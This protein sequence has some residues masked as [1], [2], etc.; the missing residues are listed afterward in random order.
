M[1]QLN[2]RIMRLELKNIEMTK[3]IEILEQISVD[4]IPILMKC[5]CVYNSVKSKTKLNILKQKYNELKLNNNNTNNDNNC[6]KIE[7]QI[8]N[9]SK[10][11]SKQLKENAKEF[12][13]IC[14]DEDIKESTEEPIYGKRKRGRPPKCVLDFKQND[15]NLEIIHKKILSFDKSIFKSVF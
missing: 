6:K 12:E 7:D 15:Q 1:D 8:E 13:D 9:C 11:P 2:E 5:K 14:I 4:L 3:M 10:S